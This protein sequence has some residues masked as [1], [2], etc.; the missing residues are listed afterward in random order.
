MLYAIEM[1]WFV[2]DKYYTMTEDVPVYAAALLLDPSQRRVYI[3][4]NGP[5]TGIRM[6]LAVHAK[7]GRQSTIQSS[8][9]SQNVLGISQHL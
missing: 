4:Q 7:F 1:G 5:R 3:E 9:Q 8:H 6:Q 2:L